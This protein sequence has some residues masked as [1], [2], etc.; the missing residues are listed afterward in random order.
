MEA[1]YMIIVQAIGFLKLDFRLLITGNLPLFLIYI[2]SIIQQIIFDHPYQYFVNEFYYREKHV[3]S[4][5]RAFKIVQDLHMHVNSEYRKIITQYEVLESK[6]NRLERKINEYDNIWK[7]TFY[8]ND[9]RLLNEENEN[10]T[11]SKDENVDRIH[12]EKDK[13]DKFKEEMVILIEELVINNSGFSGY[14][15]FNNVLK[16][17]HKILTT[18][19]TDQINQLCYDT[20]TIVKFG[21]D[22]D[23]ERDN[24]IAKI[25]IDLLEKLNKNLKILQKEKKL[26]EKQK[27][28]K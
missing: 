6:L 18:E 7:Q 21:E 3:N 19:I 8:K 24:K 20:N 5:S 10:L 14:I 17:F 23:N 1:V 4:K 28:F 13:L 15:G 27:L 22:E 12:S 16:A 2:A 11:N 25:K 9:E 26:L